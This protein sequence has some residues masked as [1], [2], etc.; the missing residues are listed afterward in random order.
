[1]G[2]VSQGEFGQKATKRTIFQ[3]REQEYDNKVVFIL[4]LCTYPVGV[5]GIL[6][7]DGTKFSKVSTFFGNFLKLLYKF[8]SLEDCVMLNM[9]IYCLT[10]NIQSTGK[11]STVCYSYCRVSE[12][13]ISICCILE[14]IH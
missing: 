6:F 13:S 5:Y 4:N 8:I 11:F 10:L 2:V 14:R 1:M 7:F 3:D 12:H 9:I